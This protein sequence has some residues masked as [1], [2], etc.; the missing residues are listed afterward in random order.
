MI[1]LL[2]EETAVGIYKVSYAFDVDMLDG[3]D[4]VGI[5]EAAVKDAYQNATARKGLWQRGLSVSHG[6]DISRLTGF[7]ETIVEAALLLHAYHTGVAGSF[8]YLVDRN[9]HHGNVSQ[10]CHHLHVVVGTHL[11]HL[12]GF[13]DLHNEA[14]A[15]LTVSHTTQDGSIFSQQFTQ[16]SREFIRLSCQIRDSQQ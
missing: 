6:I 9:S 2:I 10:V 1:S 4:G 3:R 16:T 11:S 12:L 13:R 14:D 7:I 8:F 15:Q 5:L